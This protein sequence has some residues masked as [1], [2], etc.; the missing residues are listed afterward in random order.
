MY[1]LWYL[2]EAFYPCTHHIVTHF[3][4]TREREKGRK[5]D[6]EI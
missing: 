5:K 6:I 2:R 3:K 4:I 1:S